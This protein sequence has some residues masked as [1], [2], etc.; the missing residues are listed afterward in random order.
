MRSH[1]TGPNGSDETAASLGR[2]ALEWSAGPGRTRGDRHNDNGEAFRG[3]RHTGIHG[4]VEAAS[5]LLQSALLRP[6]AVTLRGTRC[7]PKPRKGVARE[8]LGATK[9]RK[10]VDRHSARQRQSLDMDMALV[11]KGRAQGTGRE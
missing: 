9:V 11:E 2:E 10:Q 8:L 7:G 5:G 4:N 3:K 6:A 1:L